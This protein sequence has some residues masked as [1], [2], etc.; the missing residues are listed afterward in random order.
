MQAYP[1]PDIPSSARSA[2]AVWFQR[3]F[4]FA[5]GIIIV[6]LW[7]MQ[8]AQAN[9]WREESQRA[10]V[11]NNAIPAA[12]GTIYDRSGR[13]WAANTPQWTAVVTPVFVD[14][15][16]PGPWQS[17]LDE[18]AVDKT[19]KRL[20]PDPPPG[21]LRIGQAVAE[22]VNS[23]SS[24][25]ER[26]GKKPLAPLQIVDTL[27]DYSWDPYRSA[28]V[29]EDLDHNTVMR[30]AERLYELRGLEVDR[31]FIRSYRAPEGAEAFHVIG[32]VGSIS[33]DQESL[34]RS[35]YE[36]S[37]GVG[38]CGLERMYEAVLRGRK[39]REVIRP[40]SLPEVDEQHK[41][42]AGQDLTLA[43]D[44]SL[45][46]ALEASLRE[47]VER[48]GGDAGAA[49]AMD[50]QSGEIYA[51]ASYPTFRSEWFIPGHPKEYDKLREDVE[52]DRP[53]ER[54]PYSNHAISS[55]R[56][57]ASAYKIV[58]LSA[59]LEE[60]VIDPRTHHV[61][62]T[63]KM[64]LGG[65]P[66]YC[67]FKAG[68]GGVGVV[69]SLAESCNVFYYDLG[70]RLGE[71]RLIKW[72]K[73]FGFGE[74]TGIDL[75]GEADGTVG[76][77]TYVVNVLGEE[78]WFAGHSANFAI[79]QGTILATP[80]QMAVMTGVIANGGKRVVPHVVA[81]I[82]DAGRPQPPIK[83][84][85]QPGIVPLSA[86]TLS[87]VRAGMRAVILSERG[88]A[89]AAFSGEN[90]VPVAV[91]GKTGSSEA[92]TADAWF[93]CYAPY[94]P[95]DPSNPDSVVRA[96]SAPK[97]VVTALIINGGHGADAAAPVARDVI[98]AAFDDRGEFHIRPQA[99]R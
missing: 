47:S 4:V 63:G 16:K 39:G 19:G 46:A 31:Q 10:L 73:L 92:G 32:Y 77:R 88:T 41:P 23:S 83:L 26:R 58:T 64:T 68:H 42:R 94:V 55:T 33:P 82:S 2:R 93:T 43:I 15:Y 61:F 52:K 40:N 79:G 85:R 25:P 27:C 87:Y 57:P 78:G 21:F 53:S 17:Q 29:A 36:P 70:V 99:A 90:S 24:A 48:S 7:V 76:G 97:I 6:R 56:S 71:Q 98:R 44:A 38:K 86:R 72:A 20:L 67:W 13:P 74:K 95:M 66:R 22:I 1:E 89:H 11:R 51:M 45:Q 8:V 18:L 59:A 37:D 50:P 81:Q 14:G 9:Y 62:C 69:R 65:T 12:R 3:I 35:G 34:L 49:I 28:P 30:L 91:A 96:A 84:G 60:D 80:L 54:H 5:L 75:P